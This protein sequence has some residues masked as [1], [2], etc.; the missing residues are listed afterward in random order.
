MKAAIHP[1]DLLADRDRRG[2]LRHMNLP[3]VEFH[4]LTH[5]KLNKYL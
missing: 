1:L 4:K 3:R 5:H 2:K